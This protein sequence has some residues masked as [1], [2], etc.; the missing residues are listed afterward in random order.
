[1][2]PVI[3]SL[4]NPKIKQAIRLRE[5]RHRTQTGNLIIDGLREIGVAL[6]A[7]VDLESIFMAEETL[8]SSG[9]PQHWPSHAIQPVTRRVL[10]KLAYGQ[11]DS[12]AV[13]IARAPSVKL[14]DLV[15]PPK[16]LILVLDRV[17]KPGNVGAVA[18]SAATAGAHALLLID[19]VC[20]PFN[21]N[22]IRASLGRLFTLPL[23]VASF[24][25]FSAW[26]AE[27]GIG[28]ACARVDGAASM[29][30][31]DLS[32]PLAIVLGSEA[33]GLGEAW[34]RDDWP[35]IRIPMASGADSL[36]L[37]V[38]AAVLCYEALRQRTEVN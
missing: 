19:P 9:V 24:A 2:K 29:W 36:N 14:A 11:R 7:G 10:D 17:E 26:Q 4:Q 6:E 20:D 1:M 16:P 23:A 18:R 15:L 12:L 28:L 22:A 38:S 31:A 30:E 32:G 13:A 33:C 35:A 25:E 21:P 3:E 37:S 8:A 34:R 27:L 5:R